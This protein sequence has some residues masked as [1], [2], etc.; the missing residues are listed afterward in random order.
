MNILHNFSALT[1]LGLLSPKKQHHVFNRSQERFG[2]RK[3]TTLFQTLLEKR[4]NVKIS[5][6]S[7]GPIASIYGARKVTIWRIWKRARDSLNFRTGLA[8]VS[9]NKVRKWGAPKRDRNE[10]QAAV[11]AV[12]LHKR[13]T[14]RN[15]S[16]ATTLPKSFL[17]DA[18]HKL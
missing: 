15:L 10:T 16:A 2:E 13:A 9:H 14:L 12:P 6:G 5:Y 17:F 4:F 11:S 7:V 18:R 3:K 1:R 8:N